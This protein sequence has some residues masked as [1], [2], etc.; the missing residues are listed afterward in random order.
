MLLLSRCLI[1]CHLWHGFGEESLKKIEERINNSFNSSEFLEHDI[2]YIVLPLT[3]RTGPY[4]MYAQV[5]HLDEEQLVMWALKRCYLSGSFLN[6]C[7]LWWT[8]LHLLNYFK[9][10][11]N[12]NPNYSKDARRKTR[13]YD[14]FLIPS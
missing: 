9:Y 10:K 7:C 2:C 8:A 6:P 14:C 12:Y 5:H 13:V 3:T 1:L 4:T 11:N